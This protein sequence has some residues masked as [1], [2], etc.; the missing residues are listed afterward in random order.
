M[1][2]D[3]PS[4]AIGSS[5]DCS[6]LPPRATND[7]PS[8][9]NRAKWLYG[10]LCRNDRLLGTAVSVPVAVEAKAYKYLE[11]STKNAAQRWVSALAAGVRGVVFPR[12]PAAS[13]VPLTEV[14]NRHD[15]K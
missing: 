10:D 5:C 1:K 6:G 11:S 3:G 8:G 4:G 9:A 14:N 2:Y 12:K 15:L 7:G 13:A